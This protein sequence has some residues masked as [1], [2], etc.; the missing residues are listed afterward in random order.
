VPLHHPK[1]NQKGK[2]NKINIKLEKLNKR[3]ETL[4][5]F[6]AFYNTMDGMC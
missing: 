5:V 6:K 3:K 1:R 2:E 4:L